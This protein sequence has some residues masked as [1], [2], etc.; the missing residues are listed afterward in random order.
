MAKKYCFELS[1]EKYSVLKSVLDG[2][3]VEETLFTK[4]EEIDAEKAK[5]EEEKT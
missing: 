3:K 4:S 5:T 1:D 2:V